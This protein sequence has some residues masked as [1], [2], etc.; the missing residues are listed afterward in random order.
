MNSDNRQA[1]IA[2]QQHAVQQAQAEYQQF[3]TEENGLAWFQRTWE[4]GNLLREMGELPASGNAYQAG[5]N[6]CLE[7]LNRFNSRKA[8]LRLAVSYKDLGET[9]LLQHQL[10]DAF[11]Y[12][13]QCIDYCKNLFQTEAETNAYEWRTYYSS[14]VRLGEI[15]SINGQNDEAQRW[16]QEAIQVCRNLFL[17]YHDI[18]DQANLAVFYQSIAEFYQRTG[19]LMKARM[20]LQQCAEQRE[21]LLLQDWRATNF[22]IPVLLAQTLD[23]LGNLLIREQDYVQ[24]E[25]CH[26]RALELWRQ[27]FTETQSVNDAKGLA[28]A[29]EQLG[30]TMQIAGKTEESMPLLRESLNLR[31]QL[32]QMEKTELNYITLGMIYYNLGMG[33]SGEERMKYAQRAYEVFNNLC[34]ANPNNQDYRQ[35]LNIVVRDLML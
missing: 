20:Y 21:Q 9:C 28:N 15:Y 31:R 30:V 23:P 26:L 19:N 17:E 24:A 8:K 33:C 10:D 14:L 18:L 2:A 27:R 5:F 22:D 6:I 29:L 7:L 11:Q 16:F 13:C 32:F 3:M 25:R 35:K 12:Y 1:A 34:A 4:L